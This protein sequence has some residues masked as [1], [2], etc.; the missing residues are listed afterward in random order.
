MDPRL[1]DVWRKVEFIA[2]VLESHAPSFTKMTK[3]DLTDIRDD[4]N[5]TAETVQKIRD[6][7]FPE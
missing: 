7:L 4:L 3:Q 2:G 6:D 5:E 1:P